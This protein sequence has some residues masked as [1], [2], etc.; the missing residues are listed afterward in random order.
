MCSELLHFS[1]TLQLL[2]TP[3][4]PCM[5]GPCLNYGC[6]HNC[7]FFDPSTLPFSLPNLTLSPGYHTNQ[8][9]A[10]SGDFEFENSNTPNTLLSLFTDHFQPSIYYITV[11]AVTAS[12]Q[13]IR[14]SSNGVTIDITPPEAIAPVD[15]FD[16]TYSSVRPTYFQ[17]SNDT[18][19]V[20]WAFRDLESG[21][22]D[23]Q[24]S[25]GTSPNSTDI[26]PLV[27]VGTAISGINRGLLG[28][29]NHNETYYITVVATNG[30]GLSSSATSNGVTYSASELNSTK[31]EEVVEI[32]FV[33]RLIAGADGDEEVL[34]VEQG[35]RAAITWEGVPDDVEDICK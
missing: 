20:R 17:A 26:Q 25:I 12:G 33:R 23:Y 3:C 18:I 24:W 29:L 1:L 6:S 14:T 27:S 15:H 19:S 28:V 11:E 9:D 10:S 21:I 2:S 7:T 13:Y 5:P 4:R 22:I 30:A 8:S 32:E 34:V 16:V 31:L 35:D